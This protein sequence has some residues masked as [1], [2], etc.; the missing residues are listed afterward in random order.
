VKLEQVVE[1]VVAEASREAG[2]A[3]EPLES[4]DVRDGRRLPGAGPSFDL[5]FV[6]R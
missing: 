6:D 3:S 2:C 4:F 5:L 1:A